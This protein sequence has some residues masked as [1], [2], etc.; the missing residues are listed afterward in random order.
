MKIIVTDF[1]LI[2]IKSIHGYYKRRA[3]K[4]VADKLVNKIFDA[5]ELLEQIPKAGSIEQALA[6]LKLQHRYIVAGN[7]KIIFRT[8]EAIIYV[9]DVFDTRQNPKKISE[10]NK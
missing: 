5:I 10:R 8:T 7:Y 1:A 6:E 2:Q 4:N 9:T 3:S